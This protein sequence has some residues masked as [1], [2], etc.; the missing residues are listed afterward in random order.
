MNAPLP[1]RRTPGGRAGAQPQ[2]AIGLSDLIPILLHE[3]RRYQVVLVSIFAAIALIALLI[4]LFLLP[5]KYVATTSV[6]AQESDILQPLLANRAVSTQAVDRAGLA[7]QVIFSPRVMH[8]LLAAGGW[9]EGKPSLVMQD[10]LIEQLRDRTLIKSARKDLVQ[11]TYTDNEPERAYKVTSAMADLLIE[12]SLASK[13]RESREAYEFIDKQVNDYH[14][15]L[16]EAEN[17]LQAYRSANADAQPGSTRIGA[18]RTQVEQTRMSLMELRS[19]EQALSAQLSGESA[20]TAVQTRETLYRTQLLD[21]QNKL[22]T[23]LLSYTDK[24]PDVVR[25]RHQMADIQDTMKQEELRSSQPRTGDEASEARVNPLYQEL[26]SRLADTRREIA[27]IQSRMGASEGLLGDELGRSRR[28]AASE[29]TLAELT[30]DYEVN[31]DI[32]QDMLRRRENARVS[33]RM[34][35]ERRGLT[36]RIQDPA[37]M[38]V[39]PTGL[40]FMHFAL[41]GLAAA[42]AVPLGLLFLFARFDPRVRSPSQLERRGHYALLTVVPRYRTPRDRRREFMRMA[43]SAS[44]VCAV[45]LAYGLVYGYKQMHA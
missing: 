40:R 44:I 39:R 34:D 14:D 20:V 15:K 17:N 30:R 23:L 19:R 29:S 25:I 27:A 11:I 9:M 7:R 37:Q 3:A 10:R 43:I 13:E 5:R 22:D 36:M 28:I 31:R 41:G 21:L 35:S 2:A 4:G 1:A 42:V 33:M 6:L 38:P 18:L 16:T 45:V 26:R 32:Y 8:Q 24:H 12:E